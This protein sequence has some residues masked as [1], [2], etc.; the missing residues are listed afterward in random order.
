MPLK[1][2][3]I[4][5][6]SNIERNSENSPSKMK[7]PMRW[8]DNSIR[9]VFDRF[10]DE[11]FWIDP[12]PRV[13]A[14]MSRNIFPRVD[15]TETE[16]EVKVVADVPGVNPDN[17]NLDIRDNRIR[18]TGFME[19]ESK[20]E[21]NEKPYRYERSYGEFQREIILPARVKDQE[22]KAVCKDGVLTITLPKA[23]EEKR[24]KITIEKQ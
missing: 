3:D 13:M 2:K 9:D 7:S 21:G 14:R 20:P 23:E 24:K 10:F 6:K 5:S 15:V 16:N 8:E 18:I 17:I 1:N 11:R 12:F 19:S 4:Q 22:V